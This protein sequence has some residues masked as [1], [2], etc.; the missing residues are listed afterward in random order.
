MTNG[1]YY[2]KPD[3]LYGLDLDKKTA[4]RLARKL[5]LENKQDI[6]ILSLKEQEELKDLQCGI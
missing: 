1:Q 4:E 6:R 3:I 2:G 5:Y